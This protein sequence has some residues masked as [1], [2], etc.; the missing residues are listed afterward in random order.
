MYSK[1][2]V[3][4]DLEHVEQLQKALKTAA[5]LAA[6]YKTPIVYVAVTMSGAGAVAH[7]PEEFQQV[8]DDFTKA[9]AAAT[10]ADVSSEMIISHDPAVDL[11]DK[12]LA[13]I[14]DTG[15]DLVVMGSHVPGFMEHIFASNAGAVAS[16]APVSVFVVR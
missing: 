10:G 4:V 14:T 13:A 7:N 5:N 1:I 15:A 8:L 3:P 16:H 9:Q 12:L 6:E 11:D 2:M